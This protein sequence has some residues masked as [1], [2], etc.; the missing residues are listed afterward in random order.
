MYRIAWSLLTAVTLL[1]SS[2]CASL[3][4]SSLE[5]RQKLEAQ[6]ARR[7]AALESEDRPERTVEERIAEGDRALAAG[8][9]GQ[10]L[11][12]YLEAYQLDPS[13][14]AP[15]IRLGYFY[16]VDDPE[17]AAAIFAS[18]IASEPDSASSHTGL[19]L[20][21]MAQDRLEE[22]RTS[23]ERAL[24]IDPRFPTAL[25]ALGVLYA[26]MERGDESHELARRAYESNPND[27]AIVNNLGVA[28]LAAGDWAGAEQA[29]RSA[30]LLNPGDEAL[31]N[32]LGL[33]LG[34]QGRYDEARAAFRRFGSEQAVH[35]N[36]GYVHFLN[37]DRE[38]AVRE[39]EKA[40]AVGGEQRLTIL[41]N[42]ELATSGKTPVP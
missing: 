7:A 27:A 28:Q 6:R 18:V 36:M 37:G 15:A 21:R 34:R 38:G 10:A 1:G 22:A 42:L 41:R 25:D 11:R 32:N 24:E 8:E 13:Q 20:A 2:G 5:Y 14:A 19:G 3:G 16:L 39:Y 29:F 4:S 31:Y 26:L 40:L 23:L 30:I 35:N 9:R 33:A 17:R 12:Y